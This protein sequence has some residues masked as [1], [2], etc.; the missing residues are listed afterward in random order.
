MRSEAVQFLSSSAV[1]ASVLLVP[2]LL[3]EMGFDAAAIGLV[4]SAYAASVFVSSYLFGRLA[5]EYGRRVVLRAGL[6]TCAVVSALH[7]FAAEPL[8]FLA[9]RIAM[10]AS[11][12]IFPAALLAY[13]YEQNNKIGKF[14]SY[15]SL[16]WGAGTLLAG[17][18]GLWSL[19]LPFLVSAGFY[20]SAF[21]ISLA[22]PFPKE[23]RVHLPLFPKAVILRNAHAYGAMLIRHTG[24]NMVW[25]IYPLFLTDLGATP[26]WIGGIYAVN[27]ITQFSVMQVIDRFD[28]QNLLRAGMLLS[29]VTFLLFSQATELWMIPPIQIILAISWSCM[30][31][32]ALKC[33]M[34]DDAE[35]A[36]G[37]G[38]L[39]SV[40]SISAILGSIAGGA[41]ASAFGD[42]ATMYAALCMA[43]AALAT[44][45]IVSMR[46]GR[47]A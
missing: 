18:A 22:L 28:G 6:L 5:D 16:G 34:R 19:F 7:Y 31:V 32:G 10:G 17:A 35:R 3:S 11:A 9:M 37:T 46:A 42:V 45:M 24:A 30:Y 43:L 12:G 21:L 44:H 20:L 41:I 27:S 15:G 14:V 47:G 29:A 23:G 36:T 39:G 4:V 1:F 25:V 26:L 33:I 2:I 8:T 40:T 38:V 13:A